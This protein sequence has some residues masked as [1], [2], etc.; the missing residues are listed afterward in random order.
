MTSIQYV[1]KLR[2]MALKDLPK[3]FRLPVVRWKYTQLSLSWH[4]EVIDCFLEA[5]AVFCNQSAHL[6][7]VGCQALC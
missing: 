3:R 2:H 7:G 5:T 6:W 1:G 4:F